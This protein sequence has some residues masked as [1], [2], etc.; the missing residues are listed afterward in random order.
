MDGHAREFVRNHNDV[1]AFPWAWALL[2]ERAP[3]GMMDMR[4]FLG[5]ILGVFLTI[6]VAY[7]YDASISEPSKAA[8]QTSIE[9][10]PMVNWDVVNRNWQSLSLGVRTTWNRLAAR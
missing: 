9:Q 4:L 1:R 3:R 6:G 8:A 10:R 2:A 7:L 5:I